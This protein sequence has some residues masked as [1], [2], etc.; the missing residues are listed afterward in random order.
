MDIYQTKIRFLKV[1]H[2]YLHS[3]P[4]QC[5]INIKDFSPRKKAQ[6]TTFFAI[7]NEMWRN[8]CV[9]FTISRGHPQSLRGHQGV[10]GV[11]LA[12]TRLMGLFPL[13]HYNTISSSVLLY[14]NMLIF[15]VRQRNYDLLP[16]RYCS[17]WKVILDG[18]ITK[19]PLTSL[20]TCA[21]R[22]HM[23]SSWL[24]DN[25]VHGNCH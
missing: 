21:R 11:R 6:I 24:A 16:L 17:K 13:L 23:A 1:F 15:S 7:I 18:I 3:F 19:A 9:Y 14:S 25:E 22:L 10:V 4:S 12:I 8:Y 20:I 5:N 2:H